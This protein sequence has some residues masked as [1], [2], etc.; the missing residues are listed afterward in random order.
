MFLLLKIK[1]EPPQQIQN[2]S[3]YQNI[4]SFLQMI[5]QLS[6]REISFNFS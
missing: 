2:N 6:Y 1:P 4:R 3:I 5:S